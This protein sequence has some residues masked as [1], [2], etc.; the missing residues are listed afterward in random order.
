[1]SPT[2]SSISAEKLRLMLT[3]SKASSFRYIDI[4]QA[5]NVYSTQ[6]TWAIIRFPRFNRILKLSKTFAAFQPFWQHG[7]PNNGPKTP[8]RPIPLLNSINIWTSEVITRPSSHAVV[9]MDKEFFNKW[10][11]QIMPNFVHLD[12]HLVNISMVKC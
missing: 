11:G 5:L 7:I 6:F 1:M 4:T 10:R 3:K 8:Q 9:M 2:F 12:G